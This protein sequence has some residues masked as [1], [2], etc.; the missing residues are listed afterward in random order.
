MSDKLTNR[1]IF[2]VEWDRENDGREW[3]ALDVRPIK[4]SWSEELHPNRTDSFR[5]SLPAARKLARQLTKL[6]EDDDAKKFLT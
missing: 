1:Q 3:D 2:T 5:L 6:I 4:V